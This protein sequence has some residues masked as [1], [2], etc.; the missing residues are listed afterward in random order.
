[1]RKFQQI[2][3]TWTKP[4]TPTASHSILPKERRE[5]RWESFCGRIK[6]SICQAP[7]SNEKRLNAL[8]AHISLSLMGHFQ[9]SEQTGESVRTASLLSLNEAILKLILETNVTRATSV[10]NFAQVMKMAV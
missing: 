4:S 9:E 6:V 8:L 1:M 10:Q 7:E 5:K 3:A 2:L